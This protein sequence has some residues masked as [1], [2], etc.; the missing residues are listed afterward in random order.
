MTLKKNVSW[1]E[2]SSEM[3]GELEVVLPSSKA[4]IRRLLVLISTGKQPKIAV[5]GKYNHGK[6]TLLNAL[7]GQEIFKVA[8]KRETIAVSDFSHDGVTWIDTPGLDADVHGEDDRRAMEA[9]LESADILCLVH[10]VKAGEL[11]RREMQL[12]KQ[13]MRQDSNYRSKLVLV[14][15]Q[16]DQVNPEDLNQVL[17]KIDEQLP[18]LNVSKVSA[19]RYVRGI[20][21]QKPGFVKA[22]GIPEFLAY[23]KSLKVEVAQLRKKEGKRLVRKARVEIN[24]LIND[25]KKALASAI[26]NVETFEN[27]FER[28]IQR[29]GKKVLDHAKK[30]GLG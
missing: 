3:F 21:E 9:A 27:G 23:L 28:D 18:D 29:A 14:L 13:L 7:I 6:S 19:L 20:E 22:S 5:F 24:E 10:N 25:R 30:L 16:I 1:D 2:M 11:D 15:T 17:K 8:D 26:S 4:N 12:Y